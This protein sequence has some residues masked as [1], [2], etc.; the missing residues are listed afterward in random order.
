MISTD[1][2]KLKDWL[3]GSPMEL[4][5]FIQLSIT[6]TEMVHR[7]HQQTA[8]SGGLSP[9]NISIHPNAKQAKL[10]ASVESDATYQSPEHT[11]RINRIPDR[12]SDLYTLGVLFYEMLSGEM[13]FAPKDEEDWAFVHISASPQPLC[14]INPEWK[15]P[16]QS[17]ILKLLSKSPEDRYQSSYGLLCDLKQCDKM[18]KQNRTILPFEI[19][20]SDKMSTFR[21]PETLYGRSTEMDQLKTGFEQ[22]AAGSAVLRWVTGNS[23]IGKTTLIRS[24]QP[25]VAGRGGRF[26]DGACSAERKSMSFEPILQALRQWMEQIYSDSLLYLELVRKRFNTFSEQEKK[27]IMDF[28]PEAKLLLDNVPKEQPPLNTESQVRFGELLP[29]LIRCLSESKAPLVIFL[30]NLQWA[31]TDMFSVLRTLLH[32][33]EVP[34][35]MIIGA[36]RTER[37]HGLDNGNNKEDNEQLPETPWSSTLE[38]RSVEQVNLYALVYEDVR[39]YI[40]DLMHE[41]TA[42][43]RLFARSVYHQ[44]GGNPGTLRHLLE[45]WRRESKLSFDDEKHRWSWDEE[46]LRQFSDTEGSQLLIKASFD[47]LSEETMLLLAIAATIGPSFRLS[48]LAQVS[49]YTTNDVLRLLHAAELEGLIGREDDTEAGDKEESLYL[50]LHDQVQQLMYA[51]YAERNTEW[52]LQ[53]GKQLLQSYPKRVSEMLFEVVN[54]L[55]LGMEKMTREERQELAEYNFQAGSKALSIANFSQAREYYEVGLDIVSDQEIESGSVVYNLMRGLA[56]CKYMCRDIDSAKKLLLEVKRQDR[57]LNRAD[58]VSLYID[59]IQIHTFDEDDKAVQFG[60]EALAE[61]GWTLPKRVSKVTLIKEVFQTQL[62][63]KRFRDS[64]YR[65]L[66]NEDEDHI[67]L[68]GIIHALLFSLLVQNKESLIVLYAR[69]IRRGLKKG[70]DNYLASTIGVYELLLERGLPSL[71]ESSPATNLENLQA[72]FH[73]DAIVQNRLSS[74]IGIS[75]QLE[76][77][78]EASVH[79]EKSMRWGVES[80][81]A[82]FANLAIMTYLITHTGD[83]NELANILAYFEGK[84]RQYADETTLRVVQVA[85]AYRAAL[86]DVTE[87]DSFVSIPTR[88]SKEQKQDNED[89]YSCGYRLEVAYLSGRYQEALYWANLGRE[90]E[91]EFDWVRIRKQRLF[92]A[93]TLAAMYPD[94]SLDEQKRI[95]K[96]IHKQ[97]RLM[98]KRKGFLAANTAAH[99]LLQAE[100]SKMTDDEPG[101]FRKYLSALKEA[102]AEKYGLIEGIIN[103]R[104]AIYYQEIG[105]QTGAIVATMDAST[106]YTS[107]GATAKAK[108]LQTPLFNNQDTKLSQYER[109]SFNRSNDEK[110]YNSLPTGQNRLDKVPLSL[111]TGDELHQIIKWSSKEEDGNP[112]QSFLAATLRQVGAS[113]GFIFRYQ[114]ESFHIDAEISH[115][116]LGQ[117]ASAMY[118]ES[119]MYHVLRTGEAAVL[120]D[121]T[122]SYYKMKDPYIQQ[123]G[124]R[125]IICMPIVF[126]ADESPYILY[127]E[128]TYVSCVF[129]DSS[130]N[131]LKLMINRMIYLKVLQ[132]SSDRVTSESTQLLAETSDQKLIEPLTN[133]EIEILQILAEGL[134]NKEIAE[135]LGITE[136]TVKTHVSNIYGKLGVKRR[137]QAIV[138]ARELELLRK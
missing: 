92:E 32:E 94:I 114:N 48:L 76:N 66:P 13:P 15:G 31:D 41:D 39:Q 79:L 10:M 19:G 138:R 95:R 106:A 67:A 60:S 69:F 77:P 44:T 8:F 124:A 28:L 135:S 72:T 51:R 73:S 53:I 36:Y 18:L 14:G 109:G 132:H 6:L 78:A 63:L 103:E 68:S 91:L 65:I 115:H 40:S 56:Q 112:L 133:R 23:G 134:S 22:A 96:K 104:L 46:I 75:K 119:V 2:K 100:W 80:G 97:L 71:F 93:L 5:T 42:R 57:K 129:T 105:S 47:R 84:P 21:I 30:D 4:T 49:G 16:L 54:Q 125:S 3:K 58:R 17:I 52:H 24:F 61:L 38:T 43:I 81:H 37:S 90:S 113:R 50:F 26:V 62:A 116:L 20:F 11:G 34:G 88:T 98:G 12:R 130:V 89:N 136:A 131:I 83:V 29:S 25:F 111:G 70:I 137:G 102:R 33:E 27:I 118:S 117:A 74:I 7:M 35:L 64:V 55:N 101:A 107:W 128:N 82:I 99:L 127:L 126:P 1:E 85:N 87:Q 108:Q 45:S 9:S 86:Q 59:L 123:Q 110:L 120:D 121:A 122:Q